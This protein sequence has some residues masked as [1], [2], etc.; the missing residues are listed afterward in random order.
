M[1][2]HEYL[3]IIFIWR[4]LQAKREYI[5]YIELEEHLS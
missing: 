4:F 3:E 1:Y 2:A 5:K